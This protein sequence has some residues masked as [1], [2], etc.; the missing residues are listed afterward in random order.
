MMK[1]FLLALL[2]GSAATASAQLKTIE[3]QD[4]AQHV[5]DSVQFCARVQSSRYYV[6]V[7]DKP[8][9]FYF[10]K[11]YPNHTLSIVI[12]EK[13]RR[14][15]SGPVELLYGDAELCVKGRIVLADGRPQI[16]VAAPEQVGVQP[17]SD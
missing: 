6:Q 5:G 12:W 15:F 8:T 11:S 17:E 13:N 2:M 10:G 3:V 7:A 14:N 9:V 16:E 4:A 1:L